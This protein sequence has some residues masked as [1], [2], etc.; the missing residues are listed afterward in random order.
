M[1]LRQLIKRWLGMSRPGD[2]IGYEG[3]ARVQDIV[4]GSAVEDVFL[5]NYM[6]VSEQNAERRMHNDYL[7]FVW[8]RGGVGVIA[9]LKLKPIVQER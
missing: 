9:E 8:K 1:Q 3:W 2:I 6:D 4:D 7:R 5:G